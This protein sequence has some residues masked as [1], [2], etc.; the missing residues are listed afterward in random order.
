M[1]N[2]RKP[3]S[4]S[5]KQ[6]RRRR[7]RPLPTWLK[8]QQ[9]LNDVAKRRCLMVLDVLSGAKPVSDAI[10]EAQISRGLY[11][12]LETKAVRGM[13]HA[14]S[15]GADPTQQAVGMSE[16]VKVLEAKVSRLEAEK[17]RL[18]RLLYLT[19]QVLRSGPIAMGPTRQRRASTT[20]GKKSSASSTATKPAASSSSASI[21]TTGGA[22]ARSAGNGN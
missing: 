7:S 11:Y 14:L 22:A 18:E 1:T 17:R 21:P 4:E 3:P 6:R 15:P 13:L 20:N 19:K 8:E 5:P 16:R 12:Q 2:A 9:D 10:E